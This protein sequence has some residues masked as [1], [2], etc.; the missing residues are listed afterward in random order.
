MNQ[1]ADRVFGGAPLRPLGGGRHQCLQH[2]VLGV[3][4]V[5]VPAHDGGEDPRRGIAQQVLDSGSVTHAS[6][7]SGAMTSRTSIGCSI[8]APVGPGAADT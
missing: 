2:G 1:P 7:T 3:G 5:A 4:K 6:G 8:G